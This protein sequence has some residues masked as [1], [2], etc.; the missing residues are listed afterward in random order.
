MWPAER[1]GDRPSRGPLR[2]LRVVDMST[3]L[4]G[5]YA[6]ALFAYWGADVVEIEV[7]EGDPYR[8]YGISYLAVNQAKQSLTF[9]LATSA[10]RDELERVIGGADVFIDNFRPGTREALG[11]DDDAIMRINPRLIHGRVTA[12][13]DDGAW[14]ERPGFDPSIQ[15]LSGMM[16]ATG[17]SDTPLNTTTPVHDVGAGVSMALGVLAA[18]WHR[19]S[20]GVASTVAGSLAGASNLLQCA[21]LTDFNGR[22]PAS[23]GA[24]DFIGQSAGRRFYRALDGWVA[25]AT[26]NAGDLERAFG[27]LGVSAGRIDDGTDGS[28]AASV[29]AFIIGRPGR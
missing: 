18:L 28:A 21:E 1:D 26:R 29:A 7:G 22:P 23:V 9:D 2:G 16:V 8:A 3:F 11:L 20:S 12:F 5:P 24:V 19:H 14:A 6:P 27:A 17:G 4:A 10:D 13:G 15:A 25:I